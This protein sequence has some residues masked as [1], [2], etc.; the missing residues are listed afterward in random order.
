A[1]RT[2][3]TQSGPVKKIFLPLILSPLLLAASSLPGQTFEINGQSP[4]QNA[5]Q[6]PNKRGNKATKPRGEASGIGVFGGSIDVARQA[7]AAEQALKRGNYAEA[8]NFSQKA[9][10]LAPG[11]KSLWLQ[12]G[13]ASRLA[14][15]Y[16]Q[17]IDAY[18][19]V[20]S[21]EPGSADAQS[22]LAQ[23]Y[24]RS[25]N[26]T[27]ARRLLN[28]VIAANPKRVNDILILGELEMRNGDMQRGIDLLQRAESM[29]PSAH[30]ELLMA[31]GYMKLKQPDKAKRLLDQAK[32]RAPRNPEIFR[33]VANYYRETHDYKAAI[34]TLKSIPR[35][36]PESIADLGYTYE[37]AGDKKNAA[38]TYAKAAN[39]APKIIGYQLS[40]G[41]AAINA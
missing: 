14:G 29:Q 40:A 18:N 35:P 37:L 27:E 28:Q 6:P 10:Q 36:T 32:Q 31:I 16:Q 7:R 41:Q 38:A 8:A 9:V 24:I 15:R 3:R 20:L 25:G 2:L 1:G 12:L 34:E 22:G 26:P 30:S 33:A 39:A 17:S 11:N 4:Q 23:T 19:H 5:P 21:I 13:Y